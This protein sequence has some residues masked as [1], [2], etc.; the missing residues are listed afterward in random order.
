MRNKKLM[1]QNDKK[2]K[3][4]ARERMGLAHEEAVGKLRVG[5]DGSMVKTDHQKTR[6]FFKPKEF[7]KKVASISELVQRP[8]M[9]VNLAATTLE[10][11]VKVVKGVSGDEKTG[12]LCVRTLWVKLVR[13]FKPL[14]QD[15]DFDVAEL[16]TVAKKL[17]E[18]VKK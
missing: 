11:A 5:T 2:E 16:K 1:K 9:S 18:H 17:L 8:P 15:T 12:L 4:V 10:Q 13:L 14:Q 6:K 7:M 3:C